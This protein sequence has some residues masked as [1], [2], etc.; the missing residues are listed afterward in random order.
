METYGGGITLP[1]SVLEAQV[2]DL[3]EPDPIVVATPR[4]E[5]P[6]GKKIWFTPILKRANLEGH[7]N[8]LSGNGIE[9]FQIL[10]LDRETVQVV[11]FATVKEATEDESE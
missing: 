2:R 8:E 1:K 7:L 5:E 9:V 10:P 6:P 11:C 3:K 4:A